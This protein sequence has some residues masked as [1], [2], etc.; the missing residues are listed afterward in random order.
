MNLLSLFP[1]PV[2][3]FEL[4]RDLSEEELNFAKSQ[5]TRPNMGNATSV[6]N[7]ILEKQEF[8]RV[9]EFIEASLQ[10]YFKSV[11]DAQ[12]NVDIA[13]TQSW[14]NYSAQGQWHHKHAHP[15]SFISGVFYI[16]ANHK[17]DKIYL[18]KDGYERI[19]L[20]PP[21]SWNIFNSETW[22]LEAN[23]GRLILFPSQLSHNVAPVE[24]TETR[25]SLSFN[26]FPKG[27][28]GDQNSLTELVAHW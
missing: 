4:G 15:N 11:F 25:I 6:D 17:S 5:E 24:E 9:R 26:T 27:V 28:I 3:L 10:T 22:W 8:R 1:T 21:K 2:A 14:L 12:D 18:H 20:H 13:I 23:T 7:Y 19:K 16:N